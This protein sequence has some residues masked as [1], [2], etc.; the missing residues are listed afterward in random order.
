VADSRQFEKGLAVMTAYFLAMFVGV[1]QLVLGVAVG[2]WWVRRKAATDSADER[3]MREVVF[4]CQELATAVKDDVGQYHARIE[5]TNDR[6]HSA[7]TAATDATA[8][9]GGDVKNGDGGDACSPIMEVVTG[10]VG[11]VLDLN[12]KLQHK[13]AAAEQQL[14]RQS[15]QIDAYLCEARTDALT[16]L[17]N[18]R[19]FDDELRR[20]HALWARR[21]R[22]GSLLLIDVDHFKQV[23]DHHGHP[24]GDA[25]LSALAGVLKQTMRDMDV[26]ARYG[27]EE[28]AVILPD[29]NGPVA[30]VAAER[31]RRAVESHVFPIHDT[32]LTL[33]VSVGAADFKT[34]DDV[35]ALVRRADQALYTSKTAGRNC[36][37]YHNGNWCE[38][39]RGG[40]TAAPAPPP[41]NAGSTTETAPLAAELSDACE[42]LRQ[43][44]TQVAAD[45]PSNS[46]HL[47]A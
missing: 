39:I 30:K 12:R 19:A 3:W 37:H 25:V 7:A 33:T 41:A 2:G 35:I 36:G 44:L 17:L 23:N 40:P 42:N 5:A 11:E 4:R 28:F 22:P 26:V 15:A 9:T 14:Q 34:N 46:P 10:I 20:C 6:L 31:A 29:T 16:S 24:A 18:R 27:G 21:G 1:A 8:V 45:G 32:R 13:L 47:P 43:R 38:P